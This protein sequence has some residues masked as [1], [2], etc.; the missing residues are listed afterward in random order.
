MLVW[1]VCKEKDWAR[2]DSGQAANPDPSSVS[3]K[4]RRFS[5]IVKSILFFGS[6]AQEEK[7][8]TDFWRRCLRVTMSAL[9]GHR[10]RL[11]E[12]ELWS[13]S[14]QGVEDED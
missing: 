1:I 10:R 2:K 12:L 5:A 9:D 13:G 8:E 14:H 4:K 7:R 11:A 3:N 6:A